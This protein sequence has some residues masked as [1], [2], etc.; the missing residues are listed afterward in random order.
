MYERCIYKEIDRTY[1]MKVSMDDMLRMNWTASNVKA[2][3]L[4]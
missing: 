1:G 4:T 2:K 3:I